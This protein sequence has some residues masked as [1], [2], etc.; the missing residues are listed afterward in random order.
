[1]RK[2]IRDVR[3]FMVAAE[4]ELPVRP[5]VP[6][7]EVVV[8]RDSLIEEELKE[9]RTAVLA[10]HGALEGCDEMEPYYADVADALADLHYVVAGAGLA[11][12]LPMAA[13]WDEVH[14]ANMRKFGPGS[15]K[16]EDG[17]QIKPDGWKG[18][19][20]EAIIQRAMTWSHA[21]VAEAAK[22][23]PILQF[24]AFSPLPKNLQRIAEPFAD[25]AFEMAQAPG[26]AETSAGLRKLLEAKDCA[27]R[28]A[29]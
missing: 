23:Y 26:N 6:C 11:F 9:Y 17:K 12:G 25:L 20:N 19:D 13:I 5:T 22:R 8:L 21:D 18:P 1:M 2:L 29:P 3:E 24:F 4:Q 15:R 28:A 16:R 10:L 14:A 7:A 27:V